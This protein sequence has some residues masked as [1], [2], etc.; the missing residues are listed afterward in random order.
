MSLIVS[1]CRR[2]PVVGLVVI[3]RTGSFRGLVFRPICR[4][5]DRHRHRHR[6]R[7]RRRFFLPFQIDV[8]NVPCR[9][10]EQQHLD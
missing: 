4:L 9:V 8:I 1:Q 10:A 6:R 5:D 7:R 3:R 2:L